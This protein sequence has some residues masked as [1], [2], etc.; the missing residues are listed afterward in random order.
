MPPRYLYKPHEYMICIYDETKPTRITSLLRKSRSKWKKVCMVLIF[1]SYEIQDIFPCRIREMLQ[2]SR[3][4]QRNL[5][6]A[7]LDCVRC[8][9]RGFTLYILSKRGFALR[10]CNIKAI[11]GVSRVTS[12]RVRLRP[13]LKTLIISLTR[14]YAENIYHSDANEKGRYW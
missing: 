2:V 4:Q 11:E 8:I 5:E 3:S 6:R 9:R 10:C 7:I 1:S 13:E 12:L 14:R